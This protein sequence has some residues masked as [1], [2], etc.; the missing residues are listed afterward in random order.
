MKSLI[1]FLLTVVFCSCSATAPK[2]KDPVKAPPNLEAE[3]KAAE[4]SVKA[5]DNKKAVARLKRII[6][7]H[8]DSDLT[9]DAH[10]LLGQIYTKEQ[11]QPE[12]LSSFMAIVNSGVASPLEPEAALRA[13]RLQLKMGQTAEAQAVLDRS[14]RGAQLTPEQSLELEKIKYE[15][16]VAQNKPMQALESLAKLTSDTQN[17]AEKE[18]YRILGQE[19][20]ESR[21]TEDDLETVASSDKYSGLHAPAKYRYALI[22][23]EKRQYSSARRY[24]SEVIA[25]APGTE[26]AEKSASFI[27]GI[28]ARNKVDA[29]V[30]GV[31]LPLSGKQSAIGYKA[32]RGIQLGLGIYGKNQSSFRLAIVDSE[33]N[34]D[35]ARRAV[36]RLVI[37]DNAIAIIGG[38]LSKTASAEATKAQELGVPTISLSQKAGI[39]QAGDYVFRNALTSQMQVQY[40]VEIAMTKMG[41]KNF[42]IMYPN[43]A[44][45]VEYSN[46]F[47]DEVK[48]RGGDITGAQPYDPAETDFRGHVQRLAGTFYLDDRSN[49]YQLRSKAFAEKNPKR[50]ARQG[51]PS[52]EDM[53][54]PVVDF[55][56]IFIPDAVRAVGQIAPMLAYNNVSGVKLLGTNIW[57]NP[58]LVTRGQKFVE[59][60]VFVDSFL[61]TDPA[62]INSE[63]VTSFKA[64]FEE[65]PG[66][67]EVQAYDSAMLL[68][69]IISKGENS[70]TGLRDR[71]A[72][73]ENFNGAI[74]RMSVNTDREIRRP[75]TALTV[76][77]AKIAELDAPTTK[78]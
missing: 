39:T 3:L 52:V 5:G 72:S 30:V 62:F 48:A 58:Q 4:A 59:N 49:E 38:L 18:R 37:E 57:N 74:G 60:S 24:F 75:M 8:P 54:P 6:E 45:G 44:Y 27:Q 14:F 55:D 11:K 1:P 68:R 42:A 36:E 31:V 20:V 61:N 63:F 7:K 12:A 15:L 32:L 10:F 76:K 23:A 46:L 67:T 51:G 21:L 56:A 50:S 33:S 40:L 64:A 41:M 66:L 34:P 71:I 26:M 17:P 65:E 22:M 69:Q 53:L 77:D 70:R 43:D 25:L 35:A 73:I 47:W 2:K 19:I 16:A 29:R 13:M 9:D 28:D 78:K